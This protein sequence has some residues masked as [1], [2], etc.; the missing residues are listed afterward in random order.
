MKTLI[1]SILLI[2]GGI[3]TIFGQATTFVKTDLSQAEIDKIVAKFTQNERLFREALN[4]YAFNRNATISTIG[5]GS[6]ITG[7]YRRDS[8][9]TF[10][11]D[12]AR[13]EKIQFAPIST[14]T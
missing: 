12:G 11:A 7:T 3:C 14:L 5:M 1:S 9:M 4:I 6:Q 8:F 2:L 13:V 10:S